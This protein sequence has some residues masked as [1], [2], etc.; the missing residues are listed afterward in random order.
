MTDVIVH[1]GRCADCGVELRGLNPP[2]A[3]AYFQERKPFPVQ[4]PADEVRTSSEH[5]CGECGG[6]VLL[7]TTPA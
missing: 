7:E 1:G 2:K 4:L 6:Q 5:G 3:R